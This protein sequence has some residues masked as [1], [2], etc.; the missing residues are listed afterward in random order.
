MRECANGFPIFGEM[1]H[2]FAAVV[3]TLL[4]VALGESDRLSQRLVDFSLC[5]GTIDT[6]GHSPAAMW[7]IRACSNADGTDWRLCDARP[8]VGKRCVPFPLR[9]WWGLVRMRVYDAV[10]GA[11]GEGEGRV[12][13]SLPPEVEH[14][15]TADGSMLPELEQPILVPLHERH[16]T[17]AVERWATLVDHQWC[18]S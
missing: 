9:S 1:L 11:P 14:T 6:P 5:R 16:H 18:V 12:L 4:V 10:S 8:P 3:V 2:H 15:D 7:R 17:H 13:E